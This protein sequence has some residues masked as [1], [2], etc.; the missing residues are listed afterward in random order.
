MEFGSLKPGL[1]DGRPARPA[2][3]PSLGVLCAFAMLF[4]TGM[5]CGSRQAPAPTDDEVIDDVEPIPPD[6]AGVRDHGLNRSILGLW[7]GSGCPDFGACGCGGA[8][9]LVQEFTCQMD[10]LQASDIPVS[11]YLFDGSA[12]S[13]RNS[14]VTNTC[15]GSDCCSWKLGDSVIQRLARDRVRGLVHYWGGCH[16]VDQYRRVQTR[17]GRNLL[18]FY[19]DDGSSDETLSSIAGF[20][21]E[22]APGNW[23]TIAKAYQNREPST[24]NAGLSEFANAAYV[25]DLPY[26]FAGMREGI[27]RVLAKARYLP[28]PYNEL[29]G[30]AYEDPG[31]PDEE[32]YY[33]RLHFGAFQPVMAH[34]PYGNAD[35]WRPEYGPG[36][37]AAYRYYAWLHRELGPYFMSYAIRMHEDP[38]RAVIRSGPSAY[39]MRV[40]NEIFVPFVTSPTR[41]LDLRLPAGSWID[42][43]NEERVV[44]GSIAAEPAPLGREPVFLRMGSIIPMDVQRDYTGHGTR[45][46]AGALTVLVYPSPSSSFRYYEEST[47]TWTTF[48]SR[49]SG[50]ALTLA[51]DPPPSAPLLYRI[52]RWSSRPTSV[53]IAGATVTVNQA[54]DAPE[55]GSERLV[56]ASPTSAWFY[57]ASARRL[58]VKLVQQPGL[59]RANPGE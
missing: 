2:R 19:L 42:Y 16:S 58:I 37:L 30:Y 55:V 24:T 52:G 57:D 13:M 54:G 39:S 49:L 10:R 50:S 53:G 33:R 41:A 25:G 11:V 17:L 51:A 27:A 28:A 5:A 26:D 48:T 9:D 40:G 43:W 38:R 18:G 31:A 21:K 56:N 22:T 45:E 7:W 46:S 3:W 20:M 1:N 44:S 34:T 14:S 23:E 29:T 12:W 15:S 36:L 32:T 35:P 8:R 59:S 47:A 6:A 4:A